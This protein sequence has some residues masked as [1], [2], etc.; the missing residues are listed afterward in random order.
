MKRIR[1]LPACAKCGMV[2]IDPQEY[3]PFA[4]CLMYKQCK[5]ELT[6]RD[7]LAAVVDHGHKIGVEHGKQGSGEIQTV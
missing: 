3:H 1:A 2:L 7:N 6:V 5:D 4:A